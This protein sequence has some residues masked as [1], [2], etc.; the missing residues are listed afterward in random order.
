MLLRLNFTVR[1]TLRLCQKLDN[2]PGKILTVNFPRGIKGAGRNVWMPSFLKAQPQCVP[3]RVMERSTCSPSSGDPQD[4]PTS[5][6]HT[7]G[8]WGEDTS[9]LAKRRGGLSLSLSGLTS[10]TLHTLMYKYLPLAKV[11]AALCGCQTQQKTIIQ[12]KVFTAV[13][14]KGAPASRRS[15]LI[16]PAGLRCYHE[17]PGHWPLG[18]SHPFSNG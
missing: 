7:V 2:V 13:V 17:A 14:A 4:A 8:R 9:S 15:G 6:S 5:P 10:G 3:A 18:C 1:H 11:Q 12:G 16:G